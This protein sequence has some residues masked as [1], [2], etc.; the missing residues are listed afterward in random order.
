MKA[1]FTD[2][3]YALV[4]KMAKKFAYSNTNTE[5]EEYV[6]IGLEGLIKA[7][8]TYNDDN[9]TSFSTYANTCI[10]NA[11]C[12]KQKILKRFDLQQDENVVLDGNVE[13]TN[14]DGEEENGLTNDTL[15]I[16]FADDMG[17]NN[18]TD[19]LK[20]AVCKANKDNQR[21]MEMSLLHFGLVDE[22]EQP[23]DYK[24]ISAK[25]QVSAERVRQVCVNTIKTIQQDKNTK[26]ILYGFVG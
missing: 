8:N 14:E 12:T 19:A 17:N 21:N 3:S 2:E 20:N 25:F 10:R 16:S 23:M 9:D 24:E 22:I 6:S 5:Y 13:K 26:E 4:L 1:E 18:V 15:F 11:M 7:I